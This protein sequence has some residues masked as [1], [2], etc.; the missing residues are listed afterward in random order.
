MKF[1]VAS[2]LEEEGMLQEAFDMFQSLKNNYTY[3]AL[4]KMKIEGIE[5]RIKKK[6]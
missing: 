6:R 2:C 3:P 1:I 4:L 5:K